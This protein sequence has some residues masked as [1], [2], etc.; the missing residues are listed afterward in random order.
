MEV[1][2]FQLL[3]QNPIPSRKYD[4]VP[5]GPNLTLSEKMILPNKKNITTSF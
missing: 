5:S 3:D 4:L 2:Y 1:N